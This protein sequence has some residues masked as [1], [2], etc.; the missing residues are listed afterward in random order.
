MRTPLAALLMVMAT[1]HA[2]AQTPAQNP[3]QDAAPTTDPTQVRA[4]SYVLDAAHGKITWS[5]SHLGYSTY[6]GQITDVSGQADLD[7]KDPGKNR[8]TVTIGMGSINALN[9]TLNR[10]LQ[11]PDFFDTQKFPTATFTATLVEPTS[12]TTARVAGSLTLKGVTKPV[13]FDATF[14]RAG[15]N[16]IDKRYTVG[17]DGW[18]VIKR[19]DFGVNAF[20]PAIGDDVSLR[21]EGEFKAQ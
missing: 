3:A 16:P 9:E 5:V 7:P 21:L 4:G 15:L 11:G 19:S 13:A 18:A 2:H 12:P 8:L 14:N 1:A 10:H 20:L 17:F 6:Y